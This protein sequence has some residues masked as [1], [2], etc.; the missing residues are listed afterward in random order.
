MT[1]KTIRTLFAS[2]ISRR[3]E[4]VIKV[5]QD[6]QQVIREELGEYVVTDSIRK[7]FTNILERFRE[8]PNKPH[9]GIGVWVSGFFGS[10]K[11]SFAKY[12]GLALENRK[13]L[14]EGAAPL[15]AARIGSEKATDPA[16][17]HHGTD[18]DR[19]RHL[20]RLDRPWHPNW[21]PEHHGDHVSACSCKAWGTRAIWILHSSRWIWNQK[22]GSRAFESKYQETFGK[23]W[24]QGK[25]LIAF[26]VQ[27]ASRVMHELDPE[28]NATA[29]SWWEKAKERA[30]VDAR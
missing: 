26:A 21:K 9:E 17:D 19:R 5:D 10:G 18:P 7:Q 14:G 30:D 28:T 3:I 25:T 11:S 13:I 24:N 8:T 23:H 16:R 1:V 20:R 22:V 6:D 29:D 4:E 12:L 2:D 15:L 27:Q